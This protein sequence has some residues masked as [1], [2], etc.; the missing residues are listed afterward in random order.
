MKRFVLTT[1]LRDDPTALAAYREH[2]RAVWPE[3]VAS[4]RRSG[5]EKM[6]IYLLG[7]RAVMIVE[8]DGRDPRRCFAQHRASGPRVAEWEALMTGLQQALDGASPGEWWAMM[9]RVFSL[10]DAPRGATLP[11]GGA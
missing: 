10:E 6:D 8:T 7:R 1:D 11:A 9:E 3:V 2:H 5:I 4:L